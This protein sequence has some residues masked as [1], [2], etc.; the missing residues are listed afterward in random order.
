MSATPISGVRIWLSGSIPKDATPDQAAWFTNFTKAFAKAAFQ[1]GA[2][3]VH[4]F[5][6]SLLQP[7]VDA[8]KEHRVAGGDRSRLSL[9]VSTFF[10]DRATGG[11]DTE[12]GPT[13]EE[14]K[15]ECDFQEIPRAPTRERSLEELR[16]NMAS[17]ADV[18][19]AI[20]G[21]WWKQ[22]RTKAGVP[23]EFLM[24]L[25]RGMPVFLL[26][27]RIG[28]A[29]SGYVANKPAILDNLRNGLT[30]IQNVELAVNTDVADAVSTL[31]GQIGCLPLGRRE[32]TR[33]QRFRI[34]CLDGGGLRGAFTAAA[35]AKWEEMSNLRVADHF[36]LIAGTSTGGILAIGLGLG[37]SAQEVVNFYKTQGPVIF[38]A[39]DRWD[40][41]WLK[42]SNIL[43]SKFEAPILEKQLKK[44]YNRNGKV[45]YLKD[46]DKR[47]VITSYDL[48]AN[49]L[50]LYR[51][52]HHPN[53]DSH[54]H[55]AAAVVA[56][57]T[58]AAP[59]YFAPA[60]VDDA[61]AP[62]E[63]VDGGVW[64]NC[65]AL[66]AL[67]E[68]IGILKIPLERVEMLSVGTAGLPAF[69]DA[70]RV[71]GELGWA[72]RAPNLFMNSQMEATKLYM[73]QL[74]GSR[75]LRIDDKELRKEEMD[76]PN[77]LNFL[78]ARGVKVGKDSAT[79][80]MARFVN[81]VSAAPWRRL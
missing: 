30:P 42:I 47:L 69:V 48:A 31:I 53:G 25:A 17:Q 24:A 57:A 74:L 16:N 7:L 55:L 14:L 43:Q 8:A 80:V 36:D 19:V 72:A 28:G 66:A 77:D 49:S 26:G 81:G 10:R 41:L 51:T 15:R 11:Y 12:G 4:G 1:E 39:T 23:D 63:A 33:G 54:D 56:R 64:A 61:I 21:R 62:Q 60:Q 59:T 52:G 40:R 20:G 68:A 46:S 45:A 70:P 37:L 6:P 3:I 13:V 35:L 9:F 32:T 75:F 18:L 71:E 65:P 34:L 27:S 67:G 2:Q 79:D 78:I 73:S 44:A 50:M 58:S 22:N 76:N 5:H 38:D 29:L